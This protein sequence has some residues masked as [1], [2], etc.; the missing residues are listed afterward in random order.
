MQKTIYHAHDLFC[1]LAWSPAPVRAAR[2]GAD[3]AARTG[4]VRAGLAARTGA[5]KR[6]MSLFI[7]I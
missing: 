7:V 6:D 4:A 5:E 3:Q 2:S 1:D